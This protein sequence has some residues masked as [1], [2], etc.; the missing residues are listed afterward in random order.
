M[1]YSTEYFRGDKIIGAEVA[2]I[3][4]YDARVIATDGLERDLA[5]LARY[6]FR[7]HA[8]PRK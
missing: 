3:P 8:L 7:K 1:A 2:D 4:W 5:G 6:T